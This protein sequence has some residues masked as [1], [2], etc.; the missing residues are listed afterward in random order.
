[1]SKDKDWQ[2]SEKQV[3][4]DLTGY[5]QPRS[6]G[7]EAMKGDVTTEDFLIEVKTTGKSK[8][9]IKSK[10][11]QKICKEA[12]ND[13]RRLPLVVLVFSQDYGSDSRWV[14]LP[15]MILTDLLEESVE[16]RDSVHDLVRV[17]EFDLSSDQKGKTLKQ[18]Y[19]DSHYRDI[20]SDNKWPDWEI[21][22]NYIDRIYYQEWT[23]FDYKWFKENLV[24]P[25]KKL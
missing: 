16:A 9:Y 5:T 23:M 18:D 11:F 2:I 10:V 19:L 13:G 14:F 15:T 20:R 8:K 12:R 6:G 1:M 3:A 25:L 21:T 24:N 22:F 7:L 4:E 17:T